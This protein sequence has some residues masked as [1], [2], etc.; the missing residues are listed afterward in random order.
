[1]DLTDDQL[2]QLE[3]AIN[4]MPRHSSDAFDDQ[5]RR[6]EARGLVRRTAES[7]F[8]TDDGGRALVVAGRRRQHLAVQRWGRGAKGA[9]S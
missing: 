1:M 5:M 9:P 4:G 8:T 2:D 6:L 7:W 3:A